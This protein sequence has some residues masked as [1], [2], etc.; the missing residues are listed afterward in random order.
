MWSPGLPGTLTR[1]LLL[2]GGRQA[3]PNLLL[4]RPRQV[5][6]PPRSQV[7]SNPACSGWRN[8]F[9]QAHGGAC[10]LGDVVVAGRRTL[11]PPPLRHGCPVDIQNLGDFA[12]T[13]RSTRASTSPWS[14]WG[15]SASTRPTTRCAPPALLTVGKCGTSFDN[16]L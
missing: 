14:T 10:C 8:F 13:T 2:G 15:M 5:L 7:S 11:C 1:V 4:K 16:P 6:H 9:L 3:D 12:G